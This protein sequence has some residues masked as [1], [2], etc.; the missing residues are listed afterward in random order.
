MEDVEVCGVVLPMV[1]A[2]GHSFW[3]AKHRVP[4]PSKVS[5][6]MMSNKGHGDLVHTLDVALM[7]L[8]GT[9]HVVT[10]PDHRQAKRCGLWHLDNWHGCPRFVGSNY[11]A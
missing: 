8:A 6:R 10:P 1:V 3:L 2:V 4:R 5:V 9:W 11:M 7:K